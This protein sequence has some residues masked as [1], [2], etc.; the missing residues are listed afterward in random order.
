MGYTH[1]WNN[2]TEL[3]QATWNL[4]VADAKKL[5]E[6]LPATTDTAGGCYSEDQL[7]LNGCMVSKEPVFNDNEIRFN[8]GSDDDMDLGHETFLI[9]RAGMDS[10]EFCK[11]ARKPYD[12]MVTACLLLYSH[13]FGDE[14]DVS[15]DG[16]A[17]E[18]VCASELI[19]EVLGMDLTYQGGE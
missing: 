9:K 14:T 1:Y 18:W 12:L 17:D 2:G 7:K 16:L 6:N 15:S 13:Y 11:T 19:K 10:F 4:F 5:S 3:S 8:G